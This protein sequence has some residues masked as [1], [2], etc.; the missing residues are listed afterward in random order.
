[1]NEPARD[2][3]QT[4]WPLLI[5][6]LCALSL[7]AALVAQP[8]AHFAMVYAIDTAWSAWSI[9]AYATGKRFHVAPGLYA[10]ADDSQK[11]RRIMLGIC[12]CLYLGFTALMLS[13]LLR[14]GS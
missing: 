8:T 11:H 7:V 5:A 9:Y 13:R 2:F 4:R 14:A 3:V 1:M 12:L 10:A 6:G